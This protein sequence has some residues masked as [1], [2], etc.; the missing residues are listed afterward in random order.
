MLVCN[1]PT[2]ARVLS[3]ASL[4]LIDDQL[5]GFGLDVYHTGVTAAHP[6]TVHFPKPVR[7]CNESTFTVQGI[8]LLS[9]SRRRRM[10]ERCYRSQLEG[11]ANCETQKLN[12]SKVHNGSDYTP[13]SAI[14]V[15]AGL[16][17]EKGGEQGKSSSGARV[18]PIIPAMHNEVGYRVIGQSRWRRREFGRA[19]RLSTG[20]WL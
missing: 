9:G 12:K 15:F 13:C 6:V 7:E 2:A 18:D 5:C 10:S 14:I 8:C 17:T 3:D 4:F 16:R 19:S 20:G 1:S 11:S